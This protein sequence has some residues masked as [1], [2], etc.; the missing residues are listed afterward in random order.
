M[1][2]LPGFAIGSLHLTMLYMNSMHLQLAITSFWS[3]AYQETFN[4]QTSD[5]SP[6]S[7]TCTCFLEIHYFS[8][9]T[10]KFRDN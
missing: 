9:S 7:E 10:F 6:V 4:K 8:K 2:Q 1:K 5:C 3:L